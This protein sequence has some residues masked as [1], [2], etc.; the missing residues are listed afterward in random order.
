M[1]SAMRTLLASSQYPVFK[2]QAQRGDTLR[3]ARPAVNHFFRPIFACLTSA[4]P[5]IRNAPEVGA[6]DGR[7]PPFH[8][9]IR[10]PIDRPVMQLFKPVL[11]SVGRSSLVTLP[12]PPRQRKQSVR[13]IRA[14]SRG[15][16]DERST[17]A[18]AVLPET[19]ERH[20]EDSRLTTSRVRA[21][22]VACPP[23][24]LARQDWQ[25]RYRTHAAQRPR[26]RCARRPD[27]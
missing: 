4:V 25:A 13:A 21:R 12:P 7:R 8:G 6:S 5:E 9:R 19:S 23:E 3:V 14:C 11:H 24:A 20:F 16:C 26:R 2:V 10:Y 18:H 15:L 22:S 27:R 17:E 1:W